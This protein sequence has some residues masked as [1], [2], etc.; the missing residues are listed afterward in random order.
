MNWECCWTKKE[1]KP[2]EC[3]N[4]HEGEE[5]LY[6]SY[7]RRLLE[8]CLDCTSFRNDLEKLRDDDSPVADIVSLLIGEY[9]E[10]KAQIQ[11]IVHFLNTKT[12]EIKFLHE[13][14]IVLQ[15]SLDLDEVLSVAMTAITAGKGFGINRAFLLMADKERKYLRGY[16]GI[17]PKN[18]EEA[19]HIW[20]DIGRSNLTLKEM[21]RNFRKTKLYSEKVKFHDILERMSVPLADRNHVFN[22]ALKQ[23]KAILVENA[24]NNPEIDPAL[25]AILGVTSFLVMPLISRNRRIG[26]IIADN[27]ITHKPITPQDVQSLETFAFP[28]AFALE[29]AS[30]YERLQEEVEKLMAA[31]RK[32]K[33]QQELI[34]KMEKM[35]LVGRIT[36]SIAHSIRNPLMVIGGFARS[37]LKTIAEGDQ[38]REYL[39]SIVQEARLLE[40]VLE[41]VLNYSDSLYPALDQWDVNQ[42]VISVCQEMQSRLDQRGIETELNLGPDLPPIYIDY[43]KVSYCIKTILNNAMET[44]SGVNTIWVRTWA[45]EEEVIIEI[46]D[47][48]RP[49]SKEAR[50]ALTTPFADTQELGVGLGMPLCRTILER[51]G[52]QFGME[53]SPEG[54][55]KYTLKLRIHKEEGLHGE[56]PG[57]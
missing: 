10:Q 53:N 48:G 43:K 1:I 37:L 22:R 47:N 40:D 25:A 50:E 12:R 35:A 14:S 6:T 26:I 5:D 32:L 41:E 36:S 2:G 54:G 55:T 17:G 39:E 28:V 49:L 33:E 18:Y 13:V 7:R 21:A 8:R 23:K 51:Y 4:I 27:C 9:T 38:K 52:N 29:R 31:N 30:L 20:D 34:V 24:F 45:E 3:P 57:S 19:W 44:V 16:L 11:S 15:T 46:T 56:N 42:L